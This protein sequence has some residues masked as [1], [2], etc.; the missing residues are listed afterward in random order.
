MVE[1]VTEKIGEEMPM[2]TPEE[3]EQKVYRKVKIPAGTLPTYISLS[4]YHKFC[5]KFMG[6]RAER[7]IKKNPEKF[8]KLDE[9]L[10]KAHMTF[11]VK[12]Y[13]AYV[14]TTT[15]IVGIVAGV[16]GGVLGLL[17][18]LYVNLFLGILIPI[19]MVAF[20]PTVVYFILLSSPSSKAKARAKNIDTKIAHAMSFIAAMASADVTIDVIFKELARREEYGEISKEAEWITRDT[21]LL[22]KD[23][24]TA[25]RDA[26]KRSPSTKWQEFLQG[27]ITTTT[28]GGRLKPY[29]LMKA[30]EYEREMRLGMAK[31]METLGLFAETYVTVGVAFPLFLVVIMAIMA[32]IGGGGQ[33]GMVVMVLRI[34]VYVMIPAMIGMFIF[35]I[36]NTSKEVA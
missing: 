20:L 9:D 34:V 8:Q 11:K 29:F 5:L 19:L 35:L 17:L 30:Q 15:I 18:A 6:D 24:L 4:S 7:M 2:E 12:E 36:Y 27:V 14:L 28:S 10:L 21:E 31:K 33:A 23:I 26:A 32:L 1:A 25:I 13:L 22:G 16:V 3:T